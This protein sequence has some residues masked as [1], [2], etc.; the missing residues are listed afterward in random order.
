MEAALKEASATATMRTGELQKLEETHASNSAG[1]EQRLEERA[2][3]V[4]ATIEELRQLMAG[5]V[6]SGACAAI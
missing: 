4:D 3:A 5:Q 2:A 1:I 6:R